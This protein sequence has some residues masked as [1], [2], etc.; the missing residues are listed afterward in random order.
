MKKSTLF[1]ITGIIII[2]VI[3]LFVPSML[4][5]GQ[6]NFMHNQYGMMGGFGHLGMM[7]GGLVSFGWLIPII[8]LIFVIAAGV[9]LGN[10]FSNRGSSGRAMSEQ[11]CPNC[12]KPVNAEWITCPHCSSSL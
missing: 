10:T 6:G 2:A 9:S 8:L 3:L 4:M 11:A 12:S 7:G 5:F 1:W